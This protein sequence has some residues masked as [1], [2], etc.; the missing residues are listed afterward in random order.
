MNNILDIVRHPCDSTSILNWML[1]R[2]EEDER[3][4]LM[5]LTGK[6]DGKDLNNRI[7]VKLSTIRTAFRRANDHNYKQFGIHSTLIKWET[8]DGFQYEALCLE[9]VLEAR[10]QI[11]SILAK[12][13]INFARHT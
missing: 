10:H 4:P 1:W 13:G 8:L 11:S 5:V 12:S 9:R 6:G 7:R 3:A 2:W